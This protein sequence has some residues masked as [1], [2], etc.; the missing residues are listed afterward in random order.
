M[1]NAD[2]T[3]SQVETFGNPIES[4][5]TLKSLAQEI[6]S[7]EKTASPETVARLFRVSRLGGVKRIP[8]ARDLCGT[9]ADAVF[10]ETQNR[11]PR[12]SLT[13]PPLF[14]KETFPEHF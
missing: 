1:M 11:V 12:R 5:P 8:Q 10:F 13:N 7:F 3:T 2:K 6:G 9:A 4:R 14:I